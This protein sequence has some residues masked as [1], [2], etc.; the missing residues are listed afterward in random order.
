MVCVC[1][2]LYNAFR[3]VHF[4]EYSLH[5]LK[6]KC[7]LPC[8]VQRGGRVAHVLLEA[9]CCRSPFWTTSYG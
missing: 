1:A 8:E 3:M 6:P 9:M 4:V 7:N 5:L 2:N